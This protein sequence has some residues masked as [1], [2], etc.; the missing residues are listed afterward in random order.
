MDEKFAALYKAEL[1]LQTA[2][3]I[4]TIL[5]VIIVLL[6]IIGVVA[7]MLTKRNKEIAVRKV[8]GAN[9][10]NIILL[11][12][13]E[14]ALLIVLAMIIACPLAYFI[15]ERI[16][17]NF[18]YRIGQNFAPYLLVFAIISAL[19]FVLIA[20]QCFKVAVANPVKSLRTE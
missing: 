16:L 9:A 11:F 19:T 4:A 6:G 3:N 12:L 15:T 17:Q 18:A 14:Y 8:L 5:N 2:A 1:Q 13:K 7:F 20:A 10:G